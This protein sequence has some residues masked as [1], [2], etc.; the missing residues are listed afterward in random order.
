VPFEKFINI[1]KLG[2]LI[3]HGT[4]LVYLLGALFAVFVGAT[5][6]LVKF[7]IGYVI[8]F[9]AI[10]AAVYTNNYN[11]VAIDRNA[12]HTFFSGGSSILIDH[13][14]LMKTT[15]SVAIGLYTTSI[16]L[17]FVFTV[18]FSYPP[19][20]FILILLGNLLG[21][22]YT[23]PPIKLVYRGLGELTTMVGAGFIIPGFAYFLVRGTI[24]VPFVLLSF[25]LMF[26]CL[27][28]SLYLELPDRK[29]DRLGQKCTL[30]VR[31][32]EH[33][34][35]LLGVI[36]TAVV[37]LYF[38]FLGVVPLL[39]VSLNFY[40]ITIISAIPMV[41][42]AWSLRKY[43]INPQKLSWIVFRSATGIFLVFILINAY[44][45][46]LLIS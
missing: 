5:F 38:L 42:G 21:W 27:A 30:V 12:T 4:I 7:I 14:E 15:R 33:L 46:Y 9:S 29:A 23:S 41:V 2:R 35:F 37:M 13:P 31:R 40:I 6:D 22:C 8:L 34:G 32:G 17:G 39:P 26:L 24:D 10:L 25:P 44:F 1:V 19:T 18:V 45:L 20:F 28:L 36:F 43:S 16:L 11:D 3:A